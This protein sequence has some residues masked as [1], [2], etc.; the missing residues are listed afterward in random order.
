MGE[1]WTSV[2]ADGRAGLGLVGIVSLWVVTEGL[3]R[4]VVS[5]QFRHAGGSTA[6]FRSDILVGQVASGSA[7]VCAVVWSYA[8]VW[9]AAVTALPYVVTH[10][11]LASLI[12]TGRTQRSAIRAIGRL[13]EAAGLAETNH[14]VSVERLASELGRMSGVRGR[15]LS[16]LGRA[17]VLHDVGLLCTGQEAV[18]RVG[19]S[20]GDV[21]RWSAEILG[22]TP[23][24]SR[25]VPLIAGQAD[26]FRI[27]GGT[28]DPSLDVRSQIIKVSCEVDCLRAAGLDLGELVDVLYGESAFRFSPELIRFVVPAVE[29]VDRSSQIERDSL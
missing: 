14:S 21:A 1:E 18:R 2:E 24:M 10:R 5:G 23:A 16:D 17:A 11:L 3:V 12:T 8:G 22:S 20:G 26:P 27:P 6:W 4:V 19:Y 28:P 9:A 29:R 7:V 13:P 15:A 25:V